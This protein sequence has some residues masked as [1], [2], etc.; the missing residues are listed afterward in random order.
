[1]RTYVALLRAVNI[2]GTKIAMGDLRALVA[3]L[4]YEDVTTYIQS[5]NVVFRS[6]SGDPAKIGDAIEAQIA[7]RLEL[8]VPVLVRT[9]TDLGRIIADNPFEGRAEPSRL[10]VTFL[11]ATPERSR[12]QVLEAPAGSDDFQMARREVYVHAPG[13]YGRTKLNNAF[14]E[15]KLGVVATTRNWRTV[16]ALRELAAG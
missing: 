10:H 13:G 14:F 1:M 12:A 15:R 2:G 5:G 3:S 11:A 7:R 8:D 9:P 4:G 16:T 6:R